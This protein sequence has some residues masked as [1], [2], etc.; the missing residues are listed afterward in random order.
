MAKSISR[1][2]AVKA[3]DKG[4]Q[5]SMRNYWSAEKKYLE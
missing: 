3:T 5:E 1:A 4:T 2:A